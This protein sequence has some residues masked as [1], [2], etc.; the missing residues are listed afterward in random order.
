MI[1]V[2]LVND[3]QKVL[4]SIGKGR[5]KLAV[6][7]K[8]LG[9]ASSGV[10]RSGRIR[11]HRNRSCIYYNMRHWLCLLCT[12]LRSENLSITARLKSMKNEI[13]NKRRS[14]IYGSLTIF[15]VDTYVSIINKETPCQTCRNLKHTRHATNH[16]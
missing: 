6:K 11:A 13:S 14:L 8:L 3:S 2:I 12:R 16:L 9:E 1:K 5:N 15:S 4:F 7:A 10:V